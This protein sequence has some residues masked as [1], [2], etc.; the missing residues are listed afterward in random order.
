MVVFVN[1]QLYANLLL[2]GL[3]YISVHSQLHE[4]L[5]MYGPQV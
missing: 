5:P 2:T 1:S 3:K 4:N